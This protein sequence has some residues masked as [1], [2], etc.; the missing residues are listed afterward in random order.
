[1]YGSG[2][3][4]YLGNFLPQELPV[5]PAV[6]AFGWWV[7]VLGSVVACG[8]GGGGNGGGGGPDVSIA[9][10]DGDAQTGPVGTALG[11]SIVVLVQQDGAPA[12]GVTVTWTAQGTGATV[13]PVSS[14]TDAN[15][16]AATR[17]TLGQTVG[18]QTARATLS[19]A[20][21]SPLTFNATATVG[22]PT[23]FTIASGNAQTA[24]AG[25]EF[26][27]VI[28]V[29]VA[30]Q[31]ANGIAGVTVTWTVQSGPVTLESPTSITNAQGN[32]IMTVTAGGTAGA[33]VVRA[34][35]PSVAGNLDFGLTVVVAPVRIQFGS[36]FFT[37]QRNGTSDPAV[38]TVVIG[39]PVVWTGS[40]GVHT[41]ESL[42][43]PFFT[44]SG[45]LS[46][47]GASYSFTFNAA[48]TYEYDCSIHGAQMTGR[49][50][51]IP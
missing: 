1:M 39:R 40:G 36:N 50:V 46:G 15:G 44:S 35:N 29:K 3:D 16:L 38:D 14:V 22:A 18:G 20:T 47:L 51:V 34:T 33:A 11:D 19:G 6:R 42:G 32:A 48:G 13:A 25:A 31:F 12:A 28:A 26:D 23:Q 41:V 21:G 45:N 30:D 24:D 2:P 43:P 10:S 4:P 9:K 7:L 37:S 17:W 5:R 49:I 8:G 27:N